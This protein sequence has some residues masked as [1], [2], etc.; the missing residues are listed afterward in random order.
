MGRIAIEGT[1]FP[2]R[3]LNLYETI[4]TRGINSERASASRN[5]D[6]QDIVSL[7]S[8]FVRPMGWNNSRANSGRD[9]SCHKEG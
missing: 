5:D 1:T 3:Y 2:D 4:L 9:S 7:T 6:A 8:P